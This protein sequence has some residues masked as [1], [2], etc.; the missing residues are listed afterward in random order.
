MVNGYIM[1]SLLQNEALTGG[2][3]RLRGLDWVRFS[4][5]VYCSMVKTLRHGSYDVSFRSSIHLL[6]VG[7]LFLL[8]V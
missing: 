2:T 3:E 6:R 7:I 1:C 8:P 4:S 5:V